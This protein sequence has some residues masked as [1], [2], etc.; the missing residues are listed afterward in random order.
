MN[1]LSSKVMKI[2]VG[3]AVAFIAFGCKDKA[4]QEP[5]KQEPAAAPAPQAAAKS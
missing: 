4:K 5:A 3:M 2:I 1:E